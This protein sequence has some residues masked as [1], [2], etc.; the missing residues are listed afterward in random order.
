M[1]P[2]AITMHYL[3]YNICFKNC[4]ETKANGQDHKN[5]GA[6]V[7]KESYSLKVKSLNLY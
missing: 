5:K 2:R 7:G 3:G 1:F 6:G 4:M